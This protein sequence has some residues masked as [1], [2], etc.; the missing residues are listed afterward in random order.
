[1]CLNSE[2]MQDAIVT[3]LEKND[4]EFYEPEALGIGQN[5]KAVNFACHLPSGFCSSTGLKFTTPDIT[6]FQSGIAKPFFTAL[7]E[8]FKTSSIL[9]ML[10]HLSAF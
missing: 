9:K 6:N 3:T 1:M 4:E 2:E 10:R 5:H 8:I 7:K